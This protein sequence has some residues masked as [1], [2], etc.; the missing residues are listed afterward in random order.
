M[1]SRRSLISLVFSK[2]IGRTWGL[3]YVAAFSGRW[4]KS[5]PFSFPGD[6]A[7]PQKILL[8]LPEDPLEA[9]TQLS[10]IVAILNH[11]ASSEITILG[12]ERTVPFFRNLKGVKNSAEYPIA[13]G[14]LFSPRIALLASEMC[15][16]A[17]D[18]CLVLDPC[19]PPSHLYICLKTHAKARIAYEKSGVYPFVNMHINPS[20][21]FVHQSDRYCSMARTL[22]AKPPAALRWK[23]SR[24]TVDEIEAL[25]TE[26]KL[27][28]PVR[29]AGIDVAFF[30]KRFGAT[31]TERLI[32]VLRENDAVSW[33]LFCGDAPDK[34][35]LQW[36]EMRSMPVFAGLPPARAAALIQRAVVVVAGKS[37]M[38][39]L[40]ELLTIPAVGFFLE[41]EARLYSRNTPVSVPIVYADRPATDAISACI[42]AV[43]QIIS[44]A[45]ATA[46]S[47]G[48][49][50]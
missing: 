4:Y 46:V 7:Q 44:A 9:L 49:S 33:F 38:F 36:L 35:L 40:A 15:S 39:G 14:Y 16:F 18:V 37:V 3:R 29:L 27:S 34:K 12:E 50:A 13:E 32:D 48:A 5:H 22:N 10:N 11:Y 8:I 26:G 43:A 24:Q 19:P 42:D 20:E 2:L 25:L 1:P 23:V 41:Q 31:F 30:Y 28:S 21:R 6:L 17:P 45:S 47:R